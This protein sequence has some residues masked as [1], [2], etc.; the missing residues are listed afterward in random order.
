MIGGPMSFAATDGGGRV[1][2]R[3]LKCGEGLAE[4]SILPA[5]MGALVRALARV[6]ET[7][8]TAL[9]PTDE[10]ARTER[11][12]YLKLA[13]AQRQIAIQL[14]IVAT[15]MR[16]ARDLPAAPHDMNVMTSPAAQDALKAFVDEEQILL[17]LLTSAI[18]RD[19]KMLGA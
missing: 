13:A 12:V 10:N 18:D 9:D 6:L 14:G 15:D 4:N 8:A 3:Q 19:R 16:S 7:H 11:N 5:T 2:E 1:A 17:S